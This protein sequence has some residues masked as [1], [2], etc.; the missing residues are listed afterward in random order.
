[1][2]SSIEKNIWF[3]ER[4]GENEQ[5]KHR[6]IHWLVSKK[7]AFQ[8][9][10]IGQSP[11]FGKCLIMD[12]DLQSSEKDEFVYH[13]ALVHPAM[14]MHGKPRQVL[15]LGGGEGAT[16]REVLKYR[17]IDAAYMVDIDGD[18]VGFCREHLP[19]YSA[20][21]FENPKTRL[22]IGD[23]LDFV[24]DTRLKF[25]VI[26]SDLCSPLQGGPA[27]K[28][29]TEEF[30]QALRSKL[31]PGGV[32]C[33]QIDA[34]T[35]VNMNTATTINN[36]V[37]SVF[38]SSRLYTAHIP[39]FD[40]L[41]GFLVASDRPVAL[42]LSEGEITKRVAEL[43]KGNLRF[44]DAESHRG[45]FAQPKYLRAAIAAQKAIITEN[46]PIFVSK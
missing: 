11:T 8:S 39:A 15:I 20:G 46:S 16:L 1:M 44:Y 27:Y 42:D 6:M 2:A 23:A 45:M 14:L 37:R 35:L 32:L 36:T 21:A 38:A 5:H 41:W 7:T 29:Y 13:E 22:V 18:A 40:N 26:I 25:D 30:Y 10:K 43:V 3:T 9:V 34:C 31:T 28:L 12:N 4:F 19:G 17:T 33:A 24:K